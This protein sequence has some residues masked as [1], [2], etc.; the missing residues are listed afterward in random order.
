MYSTRHG[1]TRQRRPA[2]AGTRTT[3]TGGA[4]GGDLRERILA[5]TEQ[6]FREVGYHKTTVADIA[7]AIGMSPGNIYRLFP[8]KKALNEAV[9]EGMFA[10]ITARLAAIA[11]R[12]GAG[13][14]ERLR[15]F[16]TVLYEASRDRFTADRR[17]HEMVE[18]AVAESWDVVRRYAEHVDGLLGGIVADGAARGEFRV[19]DPAVAAQCVS[20]AVLRF[21]HPALIAERA[22]EVSP[23][24]AEMLDFLL[25]GL[26]AER[27]SAGAGA[28]DG[29]A[30]RRPATTHE[31][32]RRPT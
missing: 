26:G 18:V 4:T 22:D 10:Q 3:A 16:I 20:T 17:V 6:L 25:R 24:I 14:A 30:S 12:P 2:A 8:S 5:S 15:E 29:S 21:C 1:P 19:P 13:A 28:K 11:A 23:T 31:P 9:A 7:A 27:P 32:E